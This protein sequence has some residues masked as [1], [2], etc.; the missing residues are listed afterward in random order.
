VTLPCAINLSASLREQIPVSLM[1]LFKRFNSLITL[2]FKLFARIVKQLI[3]KG[4]PFLGMLYH[5]RIILL[6]DAVF[7]AFSTQLANFNHW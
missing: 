4:L 2:S 7:Y 6:K 5:A 3:Q 1:Y